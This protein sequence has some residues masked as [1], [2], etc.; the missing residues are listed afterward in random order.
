MSQLYIL[1]RV[2]YTPVKLHRMSRL[3]DPLCGKCRQVPGDL[4]H[5]LWRCLKR[6]R[7]WSGVLL[8][9]NLVF[10][11][12]VP[13]DLI[14]CVLGILEGVILEEMVRIAFSHA[15]FQARKVIL[16]GWKSSMPT[17]VASGITHNGNTL[18]MQRYIYQH[19]G[20]SGKFERL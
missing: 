5:R 6:H 19:R 18:I 15:L 17:T 14:C 10:Q 4:I 7:Y 20:G 13:L 16:L 1:L 3:A 12:T 2:N 8:T 9:L 11:T